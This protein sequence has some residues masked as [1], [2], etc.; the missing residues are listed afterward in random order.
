MRLLPTVFLSQHDGYSPP[1]APL[2]GV[3]TMTATKPRVYRH[4]WIILWELVL[5]THEVLPLR[6]LDAL[7]TASSQV[8]LRY[9]VRTLDGWL[10]LGVSSLQY[11]YQAAPPCPIPSW[12][13]T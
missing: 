4:Q 11:R 2:T 3:V 5:V 13:T 10:T 12:I 7:S 6:A 8:M 9:H 1:I